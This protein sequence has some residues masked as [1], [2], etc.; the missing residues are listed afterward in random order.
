MLGHKKV[1][2]SGTEGGVS[3]CLNH[4]VCV[5]IIKIQEKNTIKILYIKVSNKIIKHNVEKINGVN[6]KWHLV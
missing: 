5:Q 3:K 6:S 2:L 4:N 1:I